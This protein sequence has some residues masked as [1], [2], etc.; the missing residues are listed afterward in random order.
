VRLFTLRELALEE[1]EAQRNQ[2]LKERST[3]SA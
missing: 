2:L 3:V 1:A